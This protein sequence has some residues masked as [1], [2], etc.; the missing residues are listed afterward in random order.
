MSGMCNDNKENRCCDTGNVFLPDMSEKKMKTVGLSGV[1]GAGKSSVIEIL[2]AEGITVLDCDA[3]NAQLLQKGEA[4]Y[5]A[6]V[7]LFSDSLLNTDGSI[8]TQ[9]MSNLIFSDPVKKQ[10]AEGIL[11][12]LIKQ[13]ILQEVARHA[14]EALV[15]VEVP[16]LFEV[17][18][19]D[20][21]DEIWVVAC[22]EELLL[23]RLSQY[24][25][26]PKEEALRRL[27]HQLPQQEKIEKADVVFYNNGDKE[28]LKRQICDILNV[29]RQSR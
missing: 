16:L 7:D 1:M 2:Q 12:P 8:N 10:Q 21:F 9:Y 3:I 15:V 22:D 5:N 29:K 26:I 19:E 18:W 14:Q 17:H 24:R 20:A 6:L 28:S 25:R 23:H 27:Q 13:R 4:G 11:H